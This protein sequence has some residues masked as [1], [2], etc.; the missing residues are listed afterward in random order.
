MPAGYAHVL[1]FIECFP[2]LLEPTIGEFAVAIN[3]LDED[4]SWLA[5]HHECEAFIPGTRCAERLRWIEF[6]NMAAR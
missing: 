5:L 4:R 3:K 1:S 2:A 6:D